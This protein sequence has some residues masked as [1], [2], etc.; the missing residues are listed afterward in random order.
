MIDYEEKATVTDD[1][2]K[3]ISTLARKQIELM[4]A[5][6]RAEKELKAAKIALYNVQEKE[7]PE[8]M[9]AAGMEAFTL[10]TGEK[11]SVKETL[12]ASIAQKNKNAAIAWLMD[13]GHG[14]I[15][16]EN[17]LLPF[18]K[19]EHEKVVELLEILEENGYLNH[20]VDDVVNTATVKSLI[21][22]LLEK[23]EAVPL[24]LFGAHFARKA[25]VKL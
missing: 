1:Q 7:L 24:E 17:V 6:D 19:G 20:A 13:N 25:E 15:V 18:E 9:L 16:K 11:V 10:A 14:E 12:Y 23:G 4:H 5:Y 22:E 2:I 8:A 21:K 3:T